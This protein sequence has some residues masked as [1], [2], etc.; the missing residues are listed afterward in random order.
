M[1]RSALLISL[2]LLLSGCGA[3]SLLGGE[4]KRD[5]F[6]LRGP[7]V[8]A[9]SCG[10]S[11]I[12]QLVIELPKTRGTLDSD[13]IMI[14]PS[15]LQ[16]EYLGDAVWGDP[17]PV[18][19]QRLLVETL[20]NFDAFGHV[21]REPLGLSGDIAMLSEI[22]AFNAET[23]EAGT[24][25]RLAV[26]AELIREID[27]TIIGRGRFEAVT[28]AASTRTADLIPAFDAAAQELVAEMTTWTL[29]R[30]GVNTTNCR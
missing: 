28:E 10:G 7:A 21:G 25:I 9:R 3:L 29:G 23:G 15:E 30:V 16:T 22:T 26:D 8:G 6:E 24:M 11:R 20:G 1:F 27:S 13:R 2:T 12:A 14:R 4:P 17:V 18:T 19:L 5:V